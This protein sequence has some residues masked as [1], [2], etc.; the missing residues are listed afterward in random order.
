MYL[1]KMRMGWKNSQT[2]IFQGKYFKKRHSPISHRKL[3]KSLC[4]VWK[5]VVSSANTFYFLSDMVASSYGP[6]NWDISFIRSYQ[7][8]YN[9]IPYWGF[10]QIWWGLV[11]LAKRIKNSV[12]FYSFV[13]WTRETLG[14]HVKA[15]I[16]IDFKSSAN[17]LNTLFTS[18]HAILRWSY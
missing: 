18:Q 12:L 16:I 3:G 11:V 1:R 4:M 14:I 5:S 7:G 17:Y 10:P 13:N 15:T 9:C 8:D 2:T 6:N